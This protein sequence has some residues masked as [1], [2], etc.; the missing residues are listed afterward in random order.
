MQIGYKLVFDIID[1]WPESY[2][3]GCTK[4]LPFVMWRKLRDDTLQVADKIILECE[5]YKN[6]LSV[7]N[8]ENFEVL[9]PIRKPLKKISEYESFEEDICLGY[10]GSINSLIDIEKICEIIKMLHKSNTVLVRVVGDGEKKDYFVRQMKR[11][12]A[13]VKYYG[14]IYDEE[15]LQ[16]ILGNCHFGINIYRKNTNIGLTMKSISYFQMGIPILN[17]IPGDTAY[18][19]DKFQVGINVFELYDTAVEDYISGIAEHKKQVIEVFDKY[20][21]YK[22]INCVLGSL[23]I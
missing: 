13:Y 7:M 12:G 4:L 8:P 17:S 14:K 16:Y 3:K 22:N 5:Y 20:F 1:L 18:L 10:L 6:K 19:V 15:K 11:A 2:P 9:R 21:T 23:V